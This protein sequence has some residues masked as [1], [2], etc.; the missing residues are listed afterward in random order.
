MTELA[1]QPVGKPVVV[2][3]EHKRVQE[4][5]N[6]LR[7]ARPLETLARQVGRVGKRKNVCC[8]DFEK[9]VVHVCQ[10]KLVS[11]G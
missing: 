4:I 7:E 10:L 11:V 6:K 9:P 2:V 5:G 3:V 1:V 8:I